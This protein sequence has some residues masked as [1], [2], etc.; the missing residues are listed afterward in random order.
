MKYNKKNK[1]LKARNKASFKAKIIF[2][3]SILNLKLQET[4]EKQG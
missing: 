4:K 3:K 2:F 1:L